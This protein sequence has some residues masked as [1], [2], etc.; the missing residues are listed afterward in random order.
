MVFKLDS[1]SRVSDGIIAEILAA[2]LE[3]KSTRLVHFDGK[4]GILRCIHTAK[5]SVIIALNGLHKIGNNVVH[6]KTLGTSGTIRRAS[7]KFLD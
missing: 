1:E 5:D 4:R 7:K 6:V 3:G 2:S